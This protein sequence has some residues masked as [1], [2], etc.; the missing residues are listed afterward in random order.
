MAFVKH[1]ETVELKLNLTVSRRTK[2]QLEI[3]RRAFERP[4]QE[5]AQQAIEAAVE[6]EYEAH[7]AV[8]DLAPSLDLLANR[9]QLDRAIATL[10]GLAE[11]GDTCPALAANVEQ[12]QEYQRDIPA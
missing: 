12:L 4:V 2:N 6:A 10:E 1:Q 11:R 8:V 3:L 5:V 9:E 7:M